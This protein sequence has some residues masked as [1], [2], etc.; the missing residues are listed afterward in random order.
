MTSYE[1][2]APG[3]NLFPAGGLKSPPAGNRC[4]GSLPGRRSSLPVDG[5]SD[6]EPGGDRQIYYPRLRGHEGK[7]GTWCG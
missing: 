5:D 7:E 4:V 3:K 1:L 2:P 6:F